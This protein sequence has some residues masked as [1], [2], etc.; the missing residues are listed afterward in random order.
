MNENG[1]RQ[2]SITLYRW[3]ENRMAV[4]NRIRDEDN[5]EIVVFA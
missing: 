3:I 1:S 4:C 2:I 5:M